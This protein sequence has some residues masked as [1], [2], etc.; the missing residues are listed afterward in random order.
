MTPVSGHLVHTLGHSIPGL[1]T[2]GWIFW[3]IKKGHFSLNYPCPSV[4]ILIWLKP[5]S[6][7]T[8]AQALRVA[9]VV[10]TS[11]TSM[12]LSFFLKWFFRT[13]AKAFFTLALRWFRSSSVWV[14]V[15]FIL[16]KAWTTSTLGPT[17]LRKA[18]AIHSLWLKPLLPKRRRCRGT[19]TKTV[20]SKYS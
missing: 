9:P 11:S 16:F 10:N 7:S 1:Y 5:C 20:P 18:W 8:S 15:F 2:N 6:L 14:G 4:A 19:G 17:A 12:I 13:R 3:F